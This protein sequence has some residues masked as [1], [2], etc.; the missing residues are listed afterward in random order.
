MAPTPV[1]DEAVAALLERWLSG[2]PVQW[3]RVTAGSSTPVYRVTAGGAVTYLRLAEHPGERRGAE[4]RVH[5]LAHAAGVR[6]PRVVRYE[7]APPELDRSA[8][9]TSAMPGVPLTAF[10]GDA[11]AALRRAGRDLAR[12]NAIPVI[13]YGW[14]DDVGAAGQLVAEHPARAGWVADY[15]AAT[16]TVLM[17]GTLP[18]A[19]YGP[20][21]DA[22]RAWA[23]LPDRGASH[24]AHGD[25][26]R[27]HIY[28]DPVTGAYE[29]L[30][31][32]G[33]I[34]GAD[35][36]YDL[37]HVLVHDGLDAFEVIAAGYAGIAPVAVAEVRIQAAA[38]ATRAL[39]IQ[40]GRPP[41]AYRELLRDRLEALLRSGA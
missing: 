25:F 23:A 13:G 18:D 20:L 3:Q 17:A 39:A 36:H 4:V 30:I 37:G 15:L 27:S 10:D 9:L 2:T 5:D 32:F 19:L 35:R 7:S 8:T 22:I 1:S 14:V 40:L 24:L 11:T 16:E 6:L 29:G 26:D 28:V 34:R 12:L 21:E 41:D 31:D 33:E 38:I